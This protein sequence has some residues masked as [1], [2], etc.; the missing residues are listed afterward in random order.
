MWPTIDGLR[1]LKGAEA[2]LVC[3][4]VTVMVDQLADRNRDESQSESGGD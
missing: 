3:E 1:I 2:A 4:A